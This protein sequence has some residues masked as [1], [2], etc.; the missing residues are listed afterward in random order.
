[1]NMERINF[2]LPEQQIKALRDLS[3]LTGLSVSEHIRRAISAYLS[4]VCREWVEDGDS[5]G[6][7]ED[8]GD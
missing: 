2:Y 4:M 8:D 5:G 1:M 6:Q 3:R 7:G